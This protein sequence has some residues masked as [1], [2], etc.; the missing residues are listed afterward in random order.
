MTFFRFT[1]TLLVVFMAL[2]PMNVLAAEVKKKVPEKPPVEINLDVLDA[3]GVKDPDKYLPLIKTKPRPA[4]SRPASS[5]EIKKEILPAPVP[6]QKPV[7][8]KEEA[9]QEMLE[10]I[11]ITET[12]VVEPEVRPTPKRATALRNRVISAE[13]APVTPV[14]VERMQDS[15]KSLESQLVQPSAQDILDNLQGVEQQ[16][17]E[18]EEQ[19]EYMDDTPLAM[20]N[21]VMSLAYDH[22]ATAMNEDM[23]K[24]L[25]RNI[26]SIAAQPRARIEIESFASPSAEGSRSSRRL[27]LVRAL[28]V[29]DFLIAR[30]IDSAKI[31]VKALGDRNGARTPENVEEN[32]PDRVDI[33]IVDTSNR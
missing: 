5:R 26:L 6:S 19:L 3:K 32:D 23:K 33:Y 20:Q 1:K 17:E 30:N 31:S 15:G 12:P 22:T 8:A 7:I 2:V 28:E 18:P 25:V 29:R 4:Y 27:S 14:K 16:A 10:K 21:Q 24:L 13:P 11:D 9:P